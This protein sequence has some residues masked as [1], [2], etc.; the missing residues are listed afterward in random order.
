MTWKQKT[1]K[2]L[3]NRR[4]ILDKQIARTTQIHQQ[5]PSRMEARYDSSRAEYQYLITSLES[6]LKIVRQQLITLKKKGED[7]SLWQP[8]RALINNKFCRI[9]LVPDG[10]GGPV[11]NGV[12]LVSDKSPVGLTILKKSPGLV[13][14]TKT[15]TLSP[16][17][18]NTPSN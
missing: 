14:V 10:F 7:Q 11:I 18:L 6:E 3:E 13:Q 15:S 5:S 8:K 16:A 2:F 12:R 4:S 17:A 9:L 1:R